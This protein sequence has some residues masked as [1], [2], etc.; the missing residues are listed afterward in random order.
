MTIQ[1]DSLGK[2]YLFKLA[3]NIASIP[4][5]LIMEGVLPRALGPAS[6][7]NYAFST[8][9]F[10]NFTNFLDMG[11]STCLSTSLAKRQ[12]EFGLIAF[13]FRI[14]IFMLAACLL[15][16]AATYLPGASELIMPGVPAWMAL[17][18][19]LWA[20]I[21]WTG[22][23][24]RSMNDALG[25]TTRGELVRVG[26]NIFSGMALLALFVSGLLSLPTLFL[27]QYATLGLMT[28]GFIFILRR[29]WK[30]NVNAES[31]SWRLS[32]EQL[33]SYIKEFRRYSSPLFVTALFSALMLSGERW[34]LQFFE[35]SVQ[36]G[37]FSLSQKLGAACFLFVTAITPLLMREM[38]VAHGNKDRS[39]IA[40]LLDRYAPMV[41]AFSAWLACFILI[42][43]QA[44]V[45]LFGG[46]QFAEAMLPV[47]IMALYPVHQGYGQLAGAVFYAA[48]ETRLLR[49]LT[50]ATTSLGLVFAWFMLAPAK[51]GG[52]QLGA[53][54]L[55]LKMVLVQMVAVN[56]L[57]FFGR[58]IAPFGFLRNLVHQV[59]CL[60]VLLGLAYITR[61]VTLFAGL[62]S[63]SSIPRFFCSGILYV[64]LSIPLAF[65]FPF[66]FGLA[67]GEAR[68]R[69][70]QAAAYI[71]KKK[72]G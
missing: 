33:R 42:E 16:G 45:N 37:Y 49:N 24:A 69:V 43:A 28:A 55:A 44:V 20:Y 61:H 18:A 11:T 13:Y 35:G 41:Y 52:L 46:K 22:R 31:V 14:G 62:G 6:Y 34:L 27:H 71:K 21:T 58:K 50:I 17:P 19:A 59:I 51:M 53:T 9:L 3:S 63:G 64:L 23:V 29:F 67:K 5:Y 26:V 47:Q 68:L 12:R 32:R 57:F 25:I 60:A 48:G 39:A 2:R 10:Q 8:I 65:V 7:G 4:L 54:G 30:E 15:A 40:G 66:V 70:V 56:L 38:A 72:S 36:Q 1:A